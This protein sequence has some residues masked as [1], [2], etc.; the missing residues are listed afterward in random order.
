MK[1]KTIIIYLSLIVYAFYSGCI[2][3]TREQVRD[4]INIFSD[5]KKNTVFKTSYNTPIAV[6]SS[7]III[8]PVNF[9]DNNKSR[10]YS[11]SSYKKLGY[12]S[13]TTKN[14]LFFN[15]LNDSLYLLMPDSAIHISR[16]HVNNFET[17][18]KYAAK[19]IF[20]EI[21]KPGRTAYKGNPVYLF[22]SEIDGSNFRQLSPDSSHLNYWSVPAENSV[23]IMNYLTDTNQDGKYDIQDNERLLKIDLTDLSNR[24]HLLTPEIEKILDKQLPKPENE[25]QIQD[26]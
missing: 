5:D 17:Y 6:D 24:K 13:Y 22:V 9:D 3:G 10:K 11:S 19:Y 15:S 16:Y 14:L 26:E 12:Y 23:L 4:G 18:G 8:F 21:M 2:G 25:E 20:Y 1:N 7:G